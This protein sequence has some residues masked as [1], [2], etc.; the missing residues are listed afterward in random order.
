MTLILL[1][2]RRKKLMKQLARLRINNEFQNKLYLPT[3]QKKKKKQLY[4][5]HSKQAN[6]LILFCINELSNHIC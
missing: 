5:L 6:D 3:F 4:L 2:E 1:K